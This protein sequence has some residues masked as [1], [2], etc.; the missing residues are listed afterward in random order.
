[1][2]A[3]LQKNVATVAP[4]FRQQIGAAAQA[5]LDTVAAEVATA[6]QPGDVPA[7]ISAWASALPTT[8]PSTVGAWWNNGGTISQVQP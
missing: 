3:S 6:V 4:R 2:A 1:M 8:M 5:D 7:L